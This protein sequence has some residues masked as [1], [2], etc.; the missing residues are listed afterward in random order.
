MLE[1]IS[2]PWPWYVAGPIISLIMLTLILFGKRFGLSSNLET[3]CSALG[4][5]KNCEYF[6][7]NWRAKTW[8]LVFVIGLIIGGAISQRFLTNSA[9]IGIS[10]TTKTELQYMGIEDAGM[11]GFVP[12]EIFNWESLTSA[13]GIIMIVNGGFFVGFGTRYASGCTSGHAISGLSELQFTSLIAV[14]GFFIGGL[15]VTYFVLPYLI[16]S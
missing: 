15:V 5:G 14:L 11:D 8:N 1:F 4:A 13:K 7:T 10:D 12:Q 3:M 9:E 6:N 2:Q 16:S